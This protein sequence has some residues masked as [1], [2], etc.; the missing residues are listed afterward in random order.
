[1]RSTKGGIDVAL[2]TSMAKVPEG[3]D[4]KFPLPG[5]VDGIF[6]KD[7][8]AKKPESKEGKQSGKL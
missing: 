4:V 7:P 6:I 2:Y 5:R 8:A 3:V 1:M